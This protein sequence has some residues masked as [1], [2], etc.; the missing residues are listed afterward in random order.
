MNRKTG[1]F[2]IISRVQMFMLNVSLIQHIQQWE[3]I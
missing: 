2:E 1:L 3:Q